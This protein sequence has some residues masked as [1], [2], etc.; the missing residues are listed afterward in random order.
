MLSALVYGLSGLTTSAWLMSHSA[1]VSGA[2]F[3]WLAGGIG[4]VTALIGHA[5]WPAPPGRL[6]WTG[7]GW[8]LADGVPLRQ[9]SVQIDIGGWMLLRLSPL[10]GRPRWA[11]ICAQQAGPAWHGLRVALRFHA[12]N[13]FTAAV[14]STP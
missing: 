1:A 12:G 9:V 6:C 14:A 2:W 5:S 11:A 7:Q 3:W 8:Q 13:D 10:A 4:A